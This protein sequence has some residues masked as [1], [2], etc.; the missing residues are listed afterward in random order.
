MNKENIRRGRPPVLNKAQQDDA[1]RF[2]ERAG[3]QYAAEQLNVS[4]KTIE[5]I[6]AK[7]GI[8]DRDFK[9][10]ALN[11]ISQFGPIRAAKIL[12][13]PVDILEEMPNRYQLFIRSHS[14]LFHDPS[15]LFREF[16]RGC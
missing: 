6:R 12:D 15:T 3:N 9:V 7:A 13:I 16:P 14:N 11:L 4:V 2:S 1:I 5:R 8:T 10:R